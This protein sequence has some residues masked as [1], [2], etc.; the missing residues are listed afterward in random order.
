MLLSRHECMKFESDP[1]TLARGGGRDCQ[2]R[3]E[4]TV[5]P[6]LSL[7]ENL[8]EIIH[9]HLI[10]Y[11]WQKFN[12]CIQWMQITSRLLYYT[13]L[14]YTI[15]RP[16]KASFTAYSRQG[17]PLKN[18]QKPAP[19]DLPSDPHF[20][21]TPPYTGTPRYLWTPTKTTNLPP[22]TFFSPEP[23]KI[24]IGE[25]FQAVIPDLVSYADRELNL[26]LVGLSRRCCCSC[27]FD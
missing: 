9:T 19:L 13:I 2:P 18:K 15:W 1:I 10:S 11:T 6:G 25:E 26:L 20:T 7:K 3:Q 14:Y 23:K 24:R 17:E 16:R 27:F 12:S 8:I 4:L 22:S 5:L 21:L